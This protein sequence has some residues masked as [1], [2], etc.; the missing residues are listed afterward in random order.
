MSEKN[1]HQALTEQF[2]AEPL[3]EKKPYQYTVADFMN[4]ANS[5]IGQY[6]P[7]LDKISEHDTNDIE[8]D[9]HA[10]AHFAALQTSTFLG[11]TIDALDR[12]DW[13]K[14]CSQQLHK[15]RETLQTI[16]N[17]LEAI[18]EHETVELNNDNL[19]ISKKV[20]P[21]ERL[22]EH[23]GSLEYLSE[24]LEAKLNGQE[25]LLMLKDFLDKKVGIYT[26]KDAETTPTESIDNKPPR[27]IYSSQSP[28]GSESERGF[29]R[30]VDVLEQI[31]ELFD[32]L[33]QSA[34]NVPFNDLILEDTKQSR[35]ITRQ[36]IDFYHN[37]QESSE[38]SEST[39]NQLPSIID[40]LME[41]VSIIQDA[42]LNNNRA[43]NIEARANDILQ[44]KH[45]IR[46]KAEQ[47]KKQL[48]AS[49]NGQLDR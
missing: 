24:K 41:N 3:A 49:Q 28:Q 17:A 25:A 20:S 21:A 14:A 11:Q 10:R 44:S 36:L 23:K 22:L 48:S 8:D 29:I 39:I 5:L 33:E 26:D 4:E 42:L 13:D 34:S 45:Q 46:I 18:K 37:P 19:G 27:A 9:I 32:L 47:F 38:L 40:Q 31:K 35:N 30:I 16:F 15:T 2:F 12:D 6:A 43:Q 7:P 1:H